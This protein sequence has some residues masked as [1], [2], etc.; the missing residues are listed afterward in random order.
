MNMCPTSIA[1]AVFIVRTISYMIV[2]GINFFFIPI[3]TFSTIITNKL[4]FNT[5]CV[6][7]FLGFNVIMIS[8]VG[9]GIVN[10]L[11]EN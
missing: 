1:I 9:S 5:K 8:G 4:W 6:K 7:K 10:L 2:R 11:N 3:M